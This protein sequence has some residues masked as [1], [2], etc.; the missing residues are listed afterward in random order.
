MDQLVKSGK[1]DSAIDAG[2]KRFVSEQQANADKQ[3]QQTAKVSAEASKNARKVSAGRDHIYG[4]PKADWSYIVYSDLECP[5]CKQHSGV[6]EAVAKSI[7]V[8][9]INVVFRHF[10]LPFHGEAAKKEAVAS[11][12]VAK[13]SGNDGFFK[14]TS[15][16]F[17]ASQLNGQGLP[18]GDTELLSLAKDAGA[19]DEKSFTACMQDT[20]MQDLIKED[21][22]DG[23]KSG[24][25]G[26][27][28]N[29]IR[30]NK[31]GQSFASH[32]ADR[33]GAN[34]VENTVKAFMAGAAK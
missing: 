16:I 8:D 2:V 26:T 6:P 23:A 9:K 27:P 18:G 15:A 32:G 10:P 22:A 24:I 30:N 3:R 29:I 31:T 14:F 17:Q 34:S 1:L 20:K 4:N 21:I 12:C 7:G 33:G 11:E 5:Y 19:K 28:G 13:Q 25:T